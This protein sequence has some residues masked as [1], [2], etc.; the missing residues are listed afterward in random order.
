MKKLLLAA[1]SIAALST[2]A[3]AADMP[4]KAA[5]KKVVAVPIY[6]WSGLYIG[7]HA[8]Y[9]WG[10]ADWRLVSAT[11]AVP[12]RSTTNV[13]H[14]PKGAVGGVQIG[15]NQQLGQWVYGVELSWSAA[16][17]KGTS[18][19][20]V[21]AADDNFKTKIDSIFLASGRFGYAWDRTLLYAKGGY[22]NAEIKT[23]TTDTVGASQGSASVNKRHGGYVLGVGLEYA[24]IPNWTVG[25]EYD[26][27]S[28]NKKTH[29]QVFN[30]A[31]GTTVDSVDAKVHEVL[32]RLN[33][34]FG[35]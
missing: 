9:G 4:V 32:A 18:I 25:V 30:G 8:G 31:G 20:T 16:G 10:D 13:S 28:L 11:G 5:A 23:S 3:F 15:L 12:D 27:I 33:Y 24:W 1:I 2:S 29:T 19:S 6:N 17:I 34:K 21:G 7:G 26:Y 22:A 14:K 35:S